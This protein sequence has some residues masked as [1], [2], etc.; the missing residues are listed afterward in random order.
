LQLKNT[1]AAGTNF[2]AGVVDAGGNLLLL[3]KEGLSI[4]TE[5]IFKSNYSAKLLAVRQNDIARKFF[6]SVLLTQITTNL[7]GGA[8]ENGRA[9]SGLPG[10]DNYLLS[11]YSSV[12][13][14][15]FFLDVTNRKILYVYLGTTTDEPFLSI[16]D[17]TFDPRMLFRGLITLTTGGTGGSIPMLVAVEPFFNQKHY[18]M[19]LDTPDFRQQI[20][21]DLNL[22]FPEGS[23]FPNFYTEE[24]FDSVFDTG[25][26]IASQGGSVYT[27]L[28]PTELT[29]SMLW[30]K[31]GDLVSGP[32][33][34]RAGILEEKGGALIDPTLNLE[35]TAS[36]LDVGN[37][38]GFIPT[39]SSYTYRE[40]HQPVRVPW[41]KGNSDNPRIIVR[42]VNSGPYRVIIK[43]LTLTAKYLKKRKEDR[44]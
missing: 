42:V 18:Y 31:R 30:S 40:P 32:P 10:S 19:F 27:G 5:D 14:A 1:I 11:M 8:T 4:L 15:V 33:E 7:D 44:T 2:S 35:Q 26:L 24:S 25:P 41:I 37:A 20:T 13:N 6:N 34:I 29:L 22:K 9:T 39:L 23:G 36:T 17:L 16:W 28:E 12:Y 43:G 21:Q 38:Q 3:N